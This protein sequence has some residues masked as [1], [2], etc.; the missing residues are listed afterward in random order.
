MQ[1][2]GFPIPTKSIHDTM[3]LGPNQLPQQQ[4]KKTHLLAGAVAGLVVWLCLFQIGV[5]AQ[6]PDYVEGDALV[7]FKQG[8]TVTSAQ[9]TSARHAVTLAKHFDWLS[10]QRNR[11]HGLVQSKKK[12]TAA[13]VAEL[14]A[15]PDVEVAEPNFLRHITV[16][17]APTPNDT[18]FPIQWGLN[19][20]G[21]TISGSYFTLAGIPYGPIAG[22][23]GDDIRFLDAWGMAKPSTTPVVVAVID[24]GLDINHPDISGNLWTNPGHITGDT[25]T[26]DIHG[27]DFA[28]ST[29]TITD[30]GDHGTHVCG[31]I[32]ASG[33][34]GTGVIGA[35]YKAQIMMLKVSSDGSDIS[36][37]AEIEALDYA[38]MAKSGGINVAAIN[39]SFGGGDYS[40]TEISAITACGTAGIVFCCAAGNGD[41]NGNPLDNDTTPFYP[42]SYR[43]SNMIVVA[44]SDQNNQLA[45]FSNYGPTTVDLAAPGVNIYSLM[46]LVEAQ[47]YLLMGSTPYITE[48][49]KYSGTTAAAGIT[50]KLYNCGIGNTSQFPTGVSGNIALIERG[51]LTFAQKVTNAKAAGAVAV[52]IWDNV[53]E[54]TI[55]GTLGSGTWLPTLGITMVDGTTLSSLTSSSPV[56][57]TL[58]NYPSGSYQ[59]GY[60]FMDG[61]SMATPQVTGAVAFAAMNFPTETVTQRVARIVN[62][63]TAVSAF[64]SKLRHG[65]L[66]LAKIVDTD[67][68]GLP[69]WWEIEYFGAIGQ[70]PNSDP[71]GN[72][73][74]L[75]QDFMLGLN[76]K[77]AGSKLAVSQQ[78][79]VKDGTQKD[80]TINFPTINGWTYI[81]QRSTTLASLSWTQVGGSVTG[82]GSTVQVTDAGAV[83]TYPKAF[84]RVQI[85]SSP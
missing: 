63:T 26:G 35:D 46:P 50:A 24:T 32:A 36:T 48:I 67:S 41:S 30:S 80:F 23:S 6:K 66:N 72:G 9:Q 31:I 61:T 83:T 62:N 21:Q 27:Y 59:Y 75:Y 70:N 10:A 22:T 76:P 42:A 1:L 78:S 43:L 54:E 53:A 13:L 2:G 40:A 74:T 68:N 14:K 3:L 28:L 49:F 71:Y 19:N 73:F 60:Q 17:V 8:S 20:T 33:Y 77:V 15:D 39:A 34:N 84:Y 58:A 38:A 4:E 47:N 16:A 7:I 81:V 55:G 29:G 5:A 45:N 37:S 65:L 52:V 79:V 11:V 25:Y 12:S 18:Y 82:T 51:T 69:D 44:A 64:S 85:T 57:V 56:T